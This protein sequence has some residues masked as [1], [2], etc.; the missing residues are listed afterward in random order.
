MKVSEY[1]GLAQQTNKKKRSMSMGSQKRVVIEIS[2]H[3]NCSRSRQDEQ[4][5]DRSG[6]VRLDQKSCRYKVYG[7]R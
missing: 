4:R 2:A 6:D 3:S 7:H 1:Q 5:S